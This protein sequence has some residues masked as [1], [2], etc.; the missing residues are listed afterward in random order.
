MSTNQTIETRTGQLCVPFL[1]VDDLCYTC[2]DQGGEVGPYKLYFYAVCWFVTE[3]D[4]GDSFIVC[5][6][7]DRF[8]IASNSD[9]ALSDVDIADTEF[10][11][12]SS[13]PETAFPVPV[14]RTDTV[15]SSSSW[16]V[17][18][19]CKPTCK[20][21]AKSMVVPKHYMRDIM[22]VRMREYRSVSSS[23][24]NTAL[25]FPW[26]A[27]KRK[28]PMFAVAHPCTLVQSIQYQIDPEPD[29]V[30][31]KKPRLTFAARKVRGLKWEEHEDLLRTRGL[32]RWRVILENNLAATVLGEQ[33]CHAFEQCDDDPSIAM[34]LQDTFVGKSTPTLIKRATSFFRYLSWAKSAGVVN[35]MAVDEHVVYGYMCNLRDTD[36]AAT[37]A[38]S[39]LSALRFA[40][41]TIGLKNVD[42]ALSTRVLGSASWQFRLKSPLKQSNPL[43]ANQ[44]HKLEQ[45][46]LFAKDLQS[47]LASGFFLLCLYA[48]CRFKDAMFLEHLDTD[49]IEGGFG[50]LEG[51][52]TRHKT[53]TDDQR[54]TTFL[55]IVALSHGISK[56]PWGPSW[57]SD[58]QRAG[59]LNQTFLLPAPLRNGKWSDRP[60]TSGEG[61]QW[62]REL[63]V[64]AGDTS[65]N[66]V[67]AHS[68]KTTGLSW[69][70]KA[71]LLLEERKILGHH[72]DAKFTTALTYS[73]D[74]LAA[75]LTKFAKVVEQIRDGTFQ[76]DLS[77][78]ARAF[79]QVRDN[80]LPGVDARPAEENQDDAASSSSSDSQSLDEEVNERE[81]KTLLDEFGMN[82]KVVVHNPGV[83]LHADSGLGHQVN[84][85]KPHRFKCGKPV[86]AAYKSAASIQYPIHMCLMCCPSQRN[87]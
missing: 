7:M 33:L 76:P 81:E 66:H 80:D 34:S 72:M 59:F 82:R 85:E 13:F 68:L 18:P 67:T 36:A 14:D 71:G 29:T 1:D 75:P 25:A 17:L 83:Y 51:K 19:V 44:V 20:A 15:T 64:A 11:E 49:I 16:S 78:A 21:A 73:R 30:L 9:V 57:Y 23:F 60:L 22:E 69:C 35:P 27:N 40:A 6:S 24:T 43:T 41:Y 56:H 12:V 53:S 42:K 52:T 86:T 26:E 3:K 48:C 50:F 10:F 65:N 58:M 87:Q 45:I 54:R 61:G 37:V 39:F 79:Q 31:I 32:N 84:F 63:L 77:R 55:P 5:T 47:R 38:K 8:S 70:S 74:A 46:A 4:T 2:S 28:L 62:L